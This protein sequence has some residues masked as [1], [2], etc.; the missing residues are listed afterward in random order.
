MMHAAHDAHDAMWTFRA[1]RAAPST[2][3][4]ADR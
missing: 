2:E 1:G 3:V 4:V